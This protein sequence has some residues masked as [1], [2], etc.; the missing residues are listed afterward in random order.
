MTAPAAAAPA[1]AGLVRRWRLTGLSPLATGPA[2][3]LWRA[4]S[5]AHGAVV[6]KVLGP[7]GGE[8]AR[9][10]ALMA[11]AAGAGMVRVHATAP[12]AC[13][14]D[15]LP[16]PSLGALVRGGRDDEAARILASVARA[17]GRVVP[18][19]GLAPLERHLAA[20]VDGAGT[21]WPP[22]ARAAFGPVQARARRLLATAPAPVALHGDLHH[23]NV[24][25]G[26]SGWVAI[27]PK[28]LVGDPAFETA[29]SF[30]NPLDCPD[31]ARD[32]DRIRR[33]ARTFAA[34]LGHPEDRILGWAEVLAACSALWSIEDGDD[35]GDDLQLLPVLSSL[36]QDV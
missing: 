35:P 33:L 11:A 17:V 31:L 5:P 23:D 1:P 20:L 13:L 14:M 22:A 3:R 12:R 10:F 24:L 7:R 16:G 6:L 2:A 29:N 28:G 36:R 25:R 34:A 27:D 8:D 19:A 18:P 9:G 4:E 15:W 32:R 21:G 26:P 30:R